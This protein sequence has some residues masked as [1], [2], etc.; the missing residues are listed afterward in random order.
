MGYAAKLALVRY[1]QRRQQ[2][3]HA[4]EHAEHRGHPPRHRKPALDARYFHWMRRLGPPTLLLSWLPAIGDPLC[5][6][7]GWLRLPFWPSLVYMAIGKLVRYLV[8]TGALMWIP[9]T[10]WQDIGHTLR[11]L[12]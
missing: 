1:R 8:M 10:F 3:Q 4:Q 12:F 7:A 2:H 11:T 5:T 9:N 6:L